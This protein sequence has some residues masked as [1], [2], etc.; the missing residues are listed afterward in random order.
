MNGNAPTHSHP[1]PHRHAISLV[2]LLG[3]LALGPG[4]WV[5]QLLTDYA[6]SSEACF[7]HD[8][9]HLASPPPG[10]GYEAAGLLLINLVCLTA[11]LSG[12]LIAWLCWRRTHHEDDGELQATVD[13]GEGRSRFM[14]TCGMLGNGG[15]AV[16]ICFDTVVALATPTCWSMAS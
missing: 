8:M 10:W 11:A 15:F 1:S 2:L 4:A 12:L 13:V 7:G 9:P 5:A 3:A 6:L 14:A 16:A